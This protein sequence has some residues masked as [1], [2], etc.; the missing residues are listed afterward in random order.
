[1]NVVRVT[2]SVGLIEEPI[3]QRIQKGR[4]EMEEEL[5]RSTFIPTRHLSEKLP[6]DIHGQNLDFLFQ[7][8]SGEIV[9]VNGRYEGKSPFYHPRNF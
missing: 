8:L 1:M 6:R 9:K 2:R 4:K 7:T 5:D 3:E